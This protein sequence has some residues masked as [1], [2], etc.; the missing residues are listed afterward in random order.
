MPEQK[1]LVLKPEVEKLR[2]EAHY[3]VE[4]IFEMLRKTNGRT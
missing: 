2:Q 3:L 4:S 1:F